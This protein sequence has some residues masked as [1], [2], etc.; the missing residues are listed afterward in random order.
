M[1]DRFDA[2]GGKGFQRE[3]YEV[4]LREG[5]TAAR[6]GRRGLARRLLTRA[7]YERPNDPRP[8]FWMAAITDDPQEQREHLEKALALDPTNEAARK[9]LLKLQGSLG[10]S[11]APEATPFSSQAA[12]LVSASAAATFT[13]PQCGGRMRFDPQ[14]QDLVCEYCGHVI[15]DAERSLGAFGDDSFHVAMH[16]SAAH[17]WASTRLALVCKRCGADSLLPPETKT[18]A[19]P[20]CGSNSLVRP[21]TPLE[22]YDPNGIILFKFLPEQAETQA[23]AWLAEGWLTP[24]DIKQQ[25]RRLELRPVYLPFWRFD[26]YLAVPWSCEVMVNNNMRGQEQ[27]EPRSGVYTEF[28]KDILAP[29]STALPW[30]QAARVN[31]FEL[32]SVVEFT[33]DHVAGWP[34]LTFDRSL[35]DASLD[36][37]EQVMAGL[38]ARVPGLVEVGS[39]KRSL[40]LGVSSWGDVSFQHL[41]LPFY[42]GSYTYHGQR[43]SLLVNGQ[44]GKI[45]GEKPRDNVKLAAWIALF[46]LAGLSFLVIMIL[47]LE[48]GVVR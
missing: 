34:A 6:G 40:K 9:A 46:L 30:R 29:G 48:T 39:Q 11:S 36:A 20:Y 22:L 8:W 4:I 17:A 26:G 32:N 37:R 23:R 44:T 7:A 47:L 43:F 42:L 19:C 45:W 33:P 18:I 12:G 21:E 28:F 2:G 41:L 35:S 25:A 27:W 16:T 31:P 14:K 10:Q 5:I 3:E 1:F 38:R 24:D 13:C 15:A